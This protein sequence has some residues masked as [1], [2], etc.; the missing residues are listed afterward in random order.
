MGREQTKEDVAY[1]G[2]V[3]DL[4]LTASIT[5]DCTFERSR[6]Q[7]DNILIPVE[8]IHTLRSAYAVTGVRE[9]DHKMVVAESAWETGGRREQT[10]PQEGTQIN[11]KRNTGRNTNRF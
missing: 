3:E 11:S 1:Q 8:L 5:E 6:T 4:D 9:K 2:V 7:I 10:G